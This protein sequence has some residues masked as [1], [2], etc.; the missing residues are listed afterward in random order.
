VSDSHSADAARPSSRLPLLLLD[1]SAHAAFLCPTGSSASA[2]D[3]SQKQ[4]VA[5]T[6][7]ETQSVGQEDPS[8]SS[9]PAGSTPAQEQNGSQ[10]R[11]AP[12][13]SLVLEHVWDPLAPQ[14]DASFFDDL[15][16][17]MRSE[18]A[19][20]GPVEHVSGILMN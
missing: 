4:S 14:D 16:E 2:A 12:S 1:P 7:A 18:C 6:P 13:R 19:K 8:G 15:E 17:D 9:V 10:L 3:F 5:G 11:D 20:H